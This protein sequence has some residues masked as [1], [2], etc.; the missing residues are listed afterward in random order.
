MLVASRYSNTPWSLALAEAVLKS[1]QDN[2]WLAPYVVPAALGTP[3]QPCRLLIDLTWDTLFVPSANCTG[4]CD[5]D[6]NVSRLRFYSNRSSTY[7]AQGPAASFFYGTDRFTGEVATD[8]F[9]IAG[10]E[11]DNQS[12]INVERADTLGFL[13][14]YL[15]YEGVLGLAP[16]WNHSDTPYSPLTA[17]SPWYTMVDES[18]L[19]A[20]LF[21]LD[22]PGGLFDTE[23]P[24]RSG[25]LNFGGISQKYTSSSFFH[26]PLSNYSDQVWAVEAKSITWENTTNPL[27]ED[28]TNLTLAGFDTTAWY[29]ALPG[30]WSNNIYDSVKHECNPITCYVDC[31]LRQDLPNMTFGLGGAR[32]TLTPFE[33]TSEILGQDKERLC[34][35]DVVDTDRFGFPVDAI[36]LGR[37]FMEAFYM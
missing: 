25:E 20:N 27:H 9:R 1:R 21:A 6:S 34:T 26:L 19:D 31:D 16:R 17:R 14:L 12:F 23:H 11:I 8:A 5:D 3:P 37:A 33:Y 35:F 32:I 18:I 28:F 36:V 4:A 7:S 24:D 30:N 2:F 13:D 15:G 29:F 22:L 10:L